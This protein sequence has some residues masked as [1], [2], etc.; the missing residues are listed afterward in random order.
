MSGALASATTRF[1]EHLRV[2]RRYSPST[3]ENYARALTRLHAYAERLGLQRWRELRSVQ[4]QA[5]LAEQKRTNRLLSAIVYGG[6]GFVL[7]LV[8]MQIM[9]RVRIF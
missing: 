5:L 9:V 7:G 8:V 6:L 4:L 1:L 3:L 2:E